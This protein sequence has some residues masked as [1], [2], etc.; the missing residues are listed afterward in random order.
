MAVRP[1]QSVGLQRN[2]RT[3]SVGRRRRRSSQDLS[4][5]SPDTPLP[6]PVAQ[7]AEPFIIL[8]AIAGG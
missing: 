4:H 3:E 6:A 5:D 2:S 8:A 1:A 7:D